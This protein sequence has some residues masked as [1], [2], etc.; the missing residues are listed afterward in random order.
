MTTATLDVSLWRG[1][2]QGATRPTGCRSARTRPCS[3]SSPGAAQP[4]R[5]AVLP[6]RLPR[7]HVR[8]LRHDGERPAAGPAARTSPRWRRAAGSPSR[9]WRTCRSSRISRPTWRRSSRSGRRRRAR[10][11]RRRREAAGRADHA[12]QCRPPR[13]GCGHRSASIAA[14]ATPPATPCAGTP[15]ISARPRSTAPGRWS[16]TCATPATWRVWR[17]SP[18]PAAATPVTRTSRVQEHCPLALNPTASIA[19]LKRRTLQAYLRRDR[20]WSP[21]SQRLTA[22]A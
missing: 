4:R 10:S 5:H 18:P 16:T 21:T 9:R 2:A 17:R 6:L 22:A 3:T 19:G 1:G 15:T 12:R 7:R 13:G 14:S 20:R 8:L 11:C